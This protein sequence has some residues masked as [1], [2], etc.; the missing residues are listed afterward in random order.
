VEEERRSDDYVRDILLHVEQQAMSLVPDTS[1]S[2]T[3]LFVRASGG[4]RT[5]MSQH[6]AAA[7]RLIHSVRLGLLDTPFAFTD[8]F[9]QISPAEDE[10]AAA[11][12]VSTK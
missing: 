1:L 6:L 12:L 3:P 4:M 11:W 10:A 8:S 2:T 7:H 9:I 5:L